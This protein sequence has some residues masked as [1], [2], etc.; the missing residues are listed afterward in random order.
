MGGF[1]T[2]IV[3][4]ICRIKGSDTFTPLPIN[5]E[6]L[7]EQWLQIRRVHIKTFVVGDSKREGDNEIDTT[8]CIEF[9]NDFNP[10]YLEP[11]I[12]IISVKE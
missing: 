2:Q 12:I 3:V 9:E 10:N 11:S 1:S 4:I 8:F 7:F 5:G 6:L